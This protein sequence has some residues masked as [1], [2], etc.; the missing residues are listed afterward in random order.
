MSA[1][2][3]RAAIALAVVGMLGA[4]GLVCQRVG[5][6]GRWA[7]PYSTR[8]S[9]P[10]GTRALYLLVARQ[11]AEPQRWTEDLGALP[12]GGVLVALGGCEHLASRPLARHER[13]RLV[14]WVEAGGTLLVAG[15]PDY[16][17]P[18]LGVSLD[19]PSFEECLGRSGLVGMVVRSWQRAGDDAGAAPDGG[20]SPSLPGDP[21]QVAEVIR[22]T[23]ADDA[24]PEPAWAR[25]TAAPLLGMG[26]VGLRRAASVH[27]AAGTEATELLAIDGASAGVSVRRGAGTVIALA[28]ASALTNGDL[29]ASNGAALFMRLLRDREGPVRFDEYHLGAGER[30]SF[31]RWVSEIGMLPLVLQ[32]LVVALFFAWRAGA[33]FGA[34]RRSLAEEPATT[35]SLALAVGAIFARSEDSRGALAIVVRH[36]IGRVAAHHRIDAQDAERLAVELRRRKREE[37]AGAVLG[38]ATLAREGGR[39]S[40]DLLRVTQG[41]DAL[42]ARATRE[43][44]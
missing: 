41:I 3:R 38:I 35:A 7:L 23:A 24:P 33:R 34:P 21:T 25:P 43:S 12:D 1:I 20:V 36:A 22:E 14:R 29:V 26:A 44:V 28:S 42:V 18:A 30:R 31:M 32:L 4:T 5:E 2:L 37:A 27:V 39:S 10:E 6:R 11:G 8:G 15:A 9:G 13:E 40:A 17:P 19:A 16:L